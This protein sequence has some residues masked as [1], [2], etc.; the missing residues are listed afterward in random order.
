LRIEGIDLNLF[1]F[2]WDLTWA[3]FLMNGSGK[4]YGRFGGRDPK[5][6]DTRNSL[7][8]LHYA[9]EAALAEHRK[10]PA[11]KPETPAQKPLYIEKLP[12]AKAYQKNCIHCHQVKEILRQEARN[13]GTWQRD[14]IYTYPLPENVGITLDKERGNRISVVAPNSVAAKIGLKPGDLLQ[15]LN[16]IPVRSFA[17][18]QYGLHKAPAQGQIAVAWQRDGNRLQETLD[19]PTGW[20]RTNITWRPSLLDVMPSLTVYGSDLTAQEKRALKLDEKRLAFRQEAPVHAA[21]KAM[22]VQE[23]DIILG[24]DAKVFEMT[25]EAFLGYVRQNY[26]VGDTLT[27]NLLRDGKRLDL[28]VKLK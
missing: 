14:S 19:V 7:A 12:A 17:D 28:K 5:G 3:A 1:E 8:G 2:D 16:K 22:G 4:I 13:A 11:A 18:A 24:V 25:M 26:L 15:T 23:N 21:A 6:P 10:N 20:R 27:I 9:M